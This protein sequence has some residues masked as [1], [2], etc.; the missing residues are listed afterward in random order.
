MN[1]QRFI[2]VISLRHKMHR[3]YDAAAIRAAA[4]KALWEAD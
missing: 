2:A 1:G 4:D 3:T